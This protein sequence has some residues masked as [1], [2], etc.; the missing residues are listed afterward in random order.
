[1]AKKLPAQSR[2]ANGVADEYAGT[3]PD[4]TLSLNSNEV[5]D[6]SVTEVVDLS[7]NEVRFDQ[8]LSRGQ[9]GRLN[10]NFAN[11]CSDLC[12][13]IVQLPHRYGHLFRLA[14]TRK[15]STKM[16]A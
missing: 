6:L 11:R 10:I 4:R 3:G 2:Q 7:V 9:N 8:S 14:R 1:M 5:V 15:E 16:G 12:R 13:C